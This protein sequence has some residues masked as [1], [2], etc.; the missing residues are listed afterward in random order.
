MQEATVFKPRTTDGTQ[1][2]PDKTGNKRCCF[3]F[4]FFLLLGASPRIC[5]I[6]HTCYKGYKLGKR[7]LQ[8]AWRRAVKG[9]VVERA[10]DL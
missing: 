7:G 8:S 3:F 4:F 1:L 5:L 9:E 6:L 10:D 2:C